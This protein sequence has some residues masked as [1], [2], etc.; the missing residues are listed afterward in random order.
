MKKA[1]YALSADP[2]TKG[3]ID[4]ILR[5]ADMFDELIIAIGDNPSK[6]YMLNKEERLSITKSIFKNKNNISV[7]YFQGALVDFSYKVD[8]N[9]IVRGLRNINDFQ[10]EQE[11]AAINKSLK[12]N[13]ETCFI[14]SEPNKSHISSSSSKAIVK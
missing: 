13:L 8:S 4:V 3:H 9:I 5:A 7:K 1:I 14:L 10:F 11:L 6:N 12:P 2:I